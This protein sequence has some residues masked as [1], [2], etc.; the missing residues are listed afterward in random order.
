VL[1]EFDAV[2]LPREAFERPHRDDGNLRSGFLVDLGAKRL[3]ALLSV[4]FDYV[5]EVGYIS[6]RLY[7]GDFLRVKEEAA[8]GGENDEKNADSSAYQWIDLERT[9]A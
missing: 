1:E 6:A 2:L 5:G 7:V 4:R 9:P 8:A 3:N